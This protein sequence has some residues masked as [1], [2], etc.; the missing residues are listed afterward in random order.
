LEAVA[1][2]QFKDSVIVQNDYFPVNSLRY[3]RGE[4]TYFFLKTRE[5]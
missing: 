3:A 4:I 1:G 2:T 5:K